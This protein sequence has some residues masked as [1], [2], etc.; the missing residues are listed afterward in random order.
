MSD[1]EEQRSETSLIPHIAE[2][3]AAFVKRNQVAPSELQGVI[4]SVYQALEHTRRVPEPAPQ[5]PAV[6]IKKSVQPA[7][8]TCLECGKAFKAVRRH[9]LNAHGLTPDAYRQKWQLAGDYPLVA[10]EYS[11][12]R[13]R[14]AK[15]I[16]LGRR[17]AAAR[18][19]A[20][21]TRSRK[22]AAKRKPKKAA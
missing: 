15:E 2:I 22:S 19:T 8:I 18:S 5:L 21:T 9:L 4:H 3:V 10:P 13:S 7:S 20:S 17:A 11:I 14:M 1:V 16:G 6:P 12:T